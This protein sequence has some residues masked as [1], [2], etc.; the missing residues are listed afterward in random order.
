M[1]RSLAATGIT[2]IAMSET[3]DPYHAWLGI[4]PEQQP[5]NHYQLL[6]LQVF[7]P[8]RSAPMDFTQ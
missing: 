8:D 5:P 6:G 7:E 4:P 2:G 3:F 1:F